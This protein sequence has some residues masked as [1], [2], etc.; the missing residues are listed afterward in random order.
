M[1]TAFVLLKISCGSKEKLWLKFLPSY[2]NLTFCVRKLDSIVKPDLLFK[3]IANLQFV[4]LK[5]FLKD[6]KIED[7]LS[8][9]QSTWKYIVKA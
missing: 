8:L 4:Q 7:Y 3:D 2:N 6:K 5:L 1:K 9:Y